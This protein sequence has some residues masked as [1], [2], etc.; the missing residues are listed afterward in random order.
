MFLRFHGN[1]ESPQS[2]GTNNLI[3][4]GA[5][6][7]TCYKDI[8]E[9]YPEFLTKSRRKEEKI[10]INEEYKDIYKI[11]NNEYFSIDKIAEIS[12]KSIREVINKV[13][14]MELDG[15]I[16]FELGKGYRRKEI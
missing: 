14:L 6:L 15:L 1:I 10:T 2:V 13:T 7:T 11:I 16:E 12:G 3:K 8:I 9:S 5:Y 4:K